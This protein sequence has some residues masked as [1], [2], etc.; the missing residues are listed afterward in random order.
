VQNAT[1]ALAG[2]LVAALA[3]GFLSAAAWAHPSGLGT[4]TLDLLVDRGGV[5]LVD[6]AAPRATDQDR[7]SEAE[8]TA[9]ANDVL[10]ALGGARD[11]VEVDPASSLLYHEVGFT[12]WLHSPLANTA[13]PGEVRVDTRPLQDLAATRSARL[14]LDVCRVAFP[15]QRLVVHATSPASAP[16]G[17]GA[18]NADWDRRDCASWSLAPED[19][20]VTITARVEAPVTAPAPRTL[21]LLCS[22]PSD[23]DPRST[24]VLA[25]FALVGAQPLHAR[26][27]G[28]GERASRLVAEAFVFV[29]ESAR[30]TLSVPRG[31]RDR[32]RL[33]TR[34]QRATRRV[35]ARCPDL[36]D[37]HA[38]RTSV[39][40]FGVDEPA[41]VPVIVR[42]GPHAR[43]LR[44]GVG[45]RCG[46][47][48]A[49]S[50]V[51]GR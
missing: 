32:L 46:A 40:T 27:T 38:W 5:V 35:T 28:N 25:S 14:L 12:V 17:S 44:V 15:D 9:L 31:W 48:P 36:P 41:C 21:E 26:A 23:I 2:L 45:A 11:A 22:P 33:G 3:G 24:P 1:R 16:A 19:A 13:V 49:R 51:R 47:T 39:V 18:G 6:A 29:R 7:P 20:A 50:E 8:R 34:E 37:A 43:T 4:L 42:V 10:D 30:V